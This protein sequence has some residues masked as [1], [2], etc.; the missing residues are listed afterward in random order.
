MNT[1]TT[2]WTGTPEAQQRTAQQRK[3]GYKR[4]QEQKRAQFYDPNL[5]IR[6]SLPRGR[7][8]SV[9]RQI[10]AVKKSMPYK[11]R[12]SELQALEL[13]LTHNYGLHHLILPR[14]R[15]N[16]RS[17]DFNDVKLKWVEK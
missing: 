8:M 12:K 10:R 9:R 17:I 2:F 4:Q 15:V 16:N 13:F 11:L 3:I 14:K 7:F 5:Y 6:I 1:F